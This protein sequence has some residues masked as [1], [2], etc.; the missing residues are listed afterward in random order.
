M[1]RPPCYIAA[2][3]GDPDSSI[4]RWNVDRAC[5]LARLAVALGRAPIVVHSAIAGVF[6]SDHDP[7]V[8]ALGLEVDLALVT[9]VAEAPRGEL[10]ILEGEGGALSSGVALELDAWRAARGPGGVN[11]GTWHTFGPAAVG[12]G[13]GS[14]WLDLGLRPGARP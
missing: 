13:L 12:H 9:L 11:R 1:T 8:R 6:G 3:Y 2:P 14:L 5:A 4:Q 7:E 10:W